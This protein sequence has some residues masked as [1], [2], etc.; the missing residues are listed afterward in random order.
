M[1]VF[2]SRHGEKIVTLR[3]KDFIVACA[4]RLEEFLRLFAKLLQDVL[5]LV[6]FH[7][8]LSEQ[9][10]TSDLITGAMPGS[11]A[12]LLVQHYNQLQTTY[13]CYEEVKTRKTA[14]RKAAAAI[15]VRLLVRG[16]FNGG[17]TRNLPN[18]PSSFASP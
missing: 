15:R 12:S 13:N 1:N 14:F 16:T 7:R 8:T 6:N 10:R 5:S 18:I 4:M 2:L 9:N 17:K 3:G 11:S